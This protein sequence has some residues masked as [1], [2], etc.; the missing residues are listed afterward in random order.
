MKTRNGFVSNS[1]S[2]SF[3]VAFPKKPKSFEDVH[4]MMFDG[5]DGGIQPYD[6]VDGLSYSQIAKRVWDDIK[7]KPK[8]KWSHNKVPAK[9]ND[10]KE[11]F[12]NRYYYNVGSNVYWSVR[13][14]DEKGGAWS[15]PIGKYFGSDKTV[16]NELRDFIIDIEKRRSDIQEKQHIIFKTEF[17]LK[18]PPYAR[19]GG[20]DSNGKAYTKKQI[21][22]YEKYH[23]ALEKF[24]KENVEYAKLQIELEKIWKEEYRDGKQGE[25]IDK[26]A[27]ID[28]KAFYNDYKDSFIVILSYADD[29]GESTLEH[30]EIFKNLPHVRI[31]NH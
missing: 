21:S 1:S 7:K 11:E 15:Y 20:K 26:I 4:K 8:D 30:G 6:F 17:N 22:D 31:S 5:K 24:R 14:N 23:D 18:C 9:I 2:S 3:V 10:I 16:L 28:A 19:K 29:N 27:E 12:A 25:L 13:K